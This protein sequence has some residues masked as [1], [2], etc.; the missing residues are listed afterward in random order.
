MIDVRDLAQAHV[1]ALKIE[2]A[3]NKRYLMTISPGMHM[4]K[5][6]EVLYNH[7]GPNGNKEFPK[8]KNP[9]D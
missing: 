3:K 6:A 2:E 5:F 7:Y 1:N 4:S 9:K 8:A